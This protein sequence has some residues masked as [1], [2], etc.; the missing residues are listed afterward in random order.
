M[1]QPAPQTTPTLPAPINSAGKTIAQ[2]LTDAETTLN[3][4]LAYLP[5]R[6]SAQDVS[7][8]RAALDA[9]RT[10]AEKRHA[11]LLKAVAQSAQPPIQFPDLSGLQ[12]QV[13]Q[14]GEAITV[15]QNTRVDIPAAPDLTPLERA[16]Q[17]LDERVLELETRPLPATVELCETDPLEARLAV[18]EDALGIT[19]EQ[20]AL[21]APQTPDDHLTAT[22]DTETEEYEDA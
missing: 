3:A 19:P 12:K 5:T 16:V 10:A 13:A 2:R 14:H 8:L 6:A 9:D 15:L 4:L 11:E 20:A 17:G 22:T 7:A 18:V 21:P 1:T